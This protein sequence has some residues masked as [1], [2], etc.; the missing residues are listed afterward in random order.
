MIK[1]E[2]VTVAR[3][4]HE[5]GRESGVDICDTQGDYDASDVRSK[6]APPSLRQWL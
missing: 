4:G 1:L 2:S 5:R 6:H 3:S